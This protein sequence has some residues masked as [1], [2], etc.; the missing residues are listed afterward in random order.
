MT[1]TSAFN[2]TRYEMGVIFLVNDPL[3]EAQDKA[4]C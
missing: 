2:K 3:P 4:K 1:I